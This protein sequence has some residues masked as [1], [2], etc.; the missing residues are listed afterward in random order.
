MDVGEL[1]RQVEYKFAPGSLLA[2]QALANT[3]AFEPGEERL[4][5]PGRAREWLR[6]SDL[7]TDEVSVGESEWRRLVDF[8]TAIRDLIDGNL[9]GDP[10]EAADRLRALAA[11]HPVPVAVDAGGAL[12]VDL[13]PVGSVDALIAQMIGIVLQAQIE[14]TWERLKVC[15]SDECRWAF[16]DS[17]RNRGGTWCKMETCGNVV[18]NRAYRERLRQR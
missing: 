3:F 16:Y 11:A 9:D 15:A 5:D 2:V 13:A 8:R 7:A 10:R 14:G 6:V 18:K 12:A 1:H 4:L 17:S